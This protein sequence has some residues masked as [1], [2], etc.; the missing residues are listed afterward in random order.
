MERREGNSGGNDTGIIRF[1]EERRTSEAKN[2]WVA[3]VFTLKVNN[4]EMM[5]NRI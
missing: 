1:Q 5:A 2:K 3:F 4:E